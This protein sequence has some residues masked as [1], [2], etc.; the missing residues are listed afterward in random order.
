ML[1]VKIFELSPFAENTYILYNEAKQAI[2]VDPGNYHSYED[3]QLRTFI[4]DHNLTLL[5]IYN[6]HCHLDHVFG[7]AYIKSTYN[8]PFAY[9]KEEQQI[10]ERFQQSVQLFGIPERGAIPAA[11]FYLE[12]G[13][14]IKIGDDVL[15][16]L[17][18]PGHSPGHLC[19]YCKAQKFVIAGDTLFQGSIGRTDLYKGNHAEL[20]RSIQTQLITLPKETVVYPGHGP[21]TTIGLEEMNNPFLK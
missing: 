15:D 3:V 7:V 2:I 19:F 4:N 17:F 10:A 5:G 18:V 12:E 1:Q 16:I 20:I 11:D 21:S 9:H 6:T 13:G 8:I 14:V